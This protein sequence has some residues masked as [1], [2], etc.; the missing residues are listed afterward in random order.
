M[1]LSLINLPT[2]FREAQTSRLDTQ[3]ESARTSFQEKFNW[4]VRVIGNSCVAS[5]A[6]SLM[7]AC[8]AITSN[9][10]VCKLIQPDEQTIDRAYRNA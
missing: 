8:S 2:E 5:C 10:D 9:V 3:S 4:P 6:L 1:A 7:S